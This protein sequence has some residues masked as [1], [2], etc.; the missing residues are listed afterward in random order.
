MGL[1][2]WHAWSCPYC[3]RVRAALA[4]K[5]IPFRSREIDLGEKPPE[6]LQLSPTGGVPLL[7]DEGNPVPES[8]AILELLDR[9]FPEPPL[10]PD[11]PG[12]DAVR[13]LYE[14]VNQ[15]LAPVVP[16]VVRGHGEAR[17][18]AL[19]EARRAFIELEIGLGSG[20][21]LLGRFSAADLALASFVAR[22]P[23]DARPSAM[24]FPGLSRWERAV[25]RRPAVRDQMGPK[26]P[27]AA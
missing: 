9:R 16:Q 26:L 2:L 12:R 1:E 15:L 21:Y 7:V 22:L 3:M 11:G 17:V 23:A 10:F 5:G 19:E 14:R 13:A 8:L 4:E 6:F 25:M 27:S 24:G 18:Q 20:E